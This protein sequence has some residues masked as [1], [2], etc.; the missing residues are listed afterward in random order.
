MTPESLVKVVNKKM[1]DS[2]AMGLRKLRRKLRTRGIKGLDGAYYCNTEA[3]KLLGSNASCQSSF[4]RRLSWSHNLKNQQLKNTHN[5][6]SKK[7]EIN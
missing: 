5:Y 1:K 4:K 7:S 2:R 6:S 3:S